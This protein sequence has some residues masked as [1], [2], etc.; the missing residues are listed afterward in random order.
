MEK[1]PYIHEIIIFSAPF[2]PIDGKGKK[3]PWAY[4]KAEDV[5][6]EA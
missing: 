4:V 6:L 5:M 1:L 3:Q 2:P